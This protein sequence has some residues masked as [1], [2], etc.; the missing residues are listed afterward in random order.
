MTG[1]TVIATLLVIIAVV[2]IV[3]GVVYLIE[4][5]HSL[6]SFFPGHVKNI[7]GRGNGKHSKRGLIAIAVG[8]VCLVV[9][10]AAAAT[11]RRERA[12]SYRY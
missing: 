2:A 9:A 12:S 6:P 5:A 8:V 7:A 1:R 10:V 3:V 4:P 11:G